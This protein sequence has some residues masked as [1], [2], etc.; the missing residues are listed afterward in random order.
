MRTHFNTQNPASAAPYTFARAQTD[1][2]GLLYSLETP[3]EPG[4]QMFITIHKPQGIETTPKLAFIQ[5]GLNGAAS[6]LEK[7]IKAYT[8]NGYI[9]VAP[10]ARFSNWN[11]SH[12]NVSGFT[13]ENHC[14]DLE[15]AIEAVI[16]H[17]ADIGW[18]G[19][20]FALAGFSMG[21]FAASYAGATKFQAKTDH[22]LAFAP[23]V[24]GQMQIDVRLGSPDGLANLIKEV[25][26]AQ[27]EWPAHNLLDHM[28]GFTMPVC[29]AVG[30]DDGLTPD[31]N[32]S[33]FAN[34]L[35]QAG[36]L[37]SYDVLP[38]RNHDVSDPQDRQGFS[39]YLS[40]RIKAM[41]A[42]R[43]LQLNPII[44]PQASNDP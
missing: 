38:Q 28:V 34:A 9:A 8:D 10:D 12:G 36:A 22:L 11:N 2:P 16:D 31:R 27:Q 6:S 39:A 33:L 24:S 15:R 25:P 5:H 14:R 19:N 43:A 23:V 4:S 29:V 17:A 7:I 20:T 32:V 18:T 42:A 37:V 40:G 41:E 21:G 30:R 35:R 44:A 3:G 13:I 1:K 26:L